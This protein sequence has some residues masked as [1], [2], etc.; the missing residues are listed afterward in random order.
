MAEAGRGRPRP[1]PRTTVSETRSGIR[2]RMRARFASF[3]LYTSR[4]AARRDYSVALI[5]QRVAMRATR[6][7]ENAAR[8]RAH[9][10]QDWRDYRYLVTFDNNNKS[11]DA[12]K[13]VDSTAIG[14]RP[15]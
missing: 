9:M 1:N 13:L 10:A 14:Y 5:T 6:A 11:E 3:L 7:R 2:E 15:T 8:A 12:S 4:G